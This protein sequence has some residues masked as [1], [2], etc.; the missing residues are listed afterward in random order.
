VDTAGFRLLDWVDIYFYMYTLQAIFKRSHLL[1]TNDVHTHTHTHTHSLDSTMSTHTHTHTHTHT[2]D[3]T[4]SIHTYTHTH[5]HTHC[6][7]F[8]EGRTFMI[9]QWRRW[10][11][12]ARLDYL[13]SRPRRG[14]A[15]IR[16]IYVYV[17]ICTYIYTHTHTHTHTHIHTRTHTHTHTHIRLAINCRR[18][19]PDVT[20][21]SYIE[22]KKT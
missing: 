11:H 6:R 8:T 5:T 4:M 15:I 13:R 7:L 16:S 19:R 2:L 18:P 22:L 10:T 9:R 12:Q 21:P 14:L 20:P 3:S 17:D 1:D